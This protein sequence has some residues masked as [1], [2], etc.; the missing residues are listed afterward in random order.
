MASSLRL[1]SGFLSSAVCRSVIVALNDLP[2]NSL[3]PPE[4]M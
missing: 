4:A 2:G 1:P 3:A